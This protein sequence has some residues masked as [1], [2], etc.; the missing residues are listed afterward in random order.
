M[1]VPCKHP[2]SEQQFGTESQNRRITIL[3]F[4]N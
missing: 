3:D 4:L 2:A 1:S